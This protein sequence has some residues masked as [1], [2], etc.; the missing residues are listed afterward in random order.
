[1]F[2]TGAKNIEK[3]PVNKSRK[4]EEGYFAARRES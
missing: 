4:G 2:L 1:M 3:K